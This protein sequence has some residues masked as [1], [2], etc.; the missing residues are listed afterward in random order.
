[1]CNSPRT[2]SVRRKDFTGLLQA[3]MVISSAGFH[4]SVT[5]PY[6]RVDVPCGHCAECLKKN[7]SLWKRASCARLKLIRLCFS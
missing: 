4:E 6:L 7:G 3:Q 2:I 1:M 5:S